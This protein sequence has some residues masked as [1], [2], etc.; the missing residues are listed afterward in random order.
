[1]QVCAELWNFPDRTGT[2]TGAMIQ[3]YLAS[4][5]DIGDHAVHLIFSANRHE[6]RSAGLLACE[7]SAAVVVLA[8]VVH[9]WQQAMSKALLQEG[10]HMPAFVGMLGSRAQAHF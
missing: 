2:H 5:S 8:V 3:E 4:K 6:K 9:R 7:L 1:M 10:M